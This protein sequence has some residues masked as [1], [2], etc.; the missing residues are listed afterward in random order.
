MN[1]ISIVLPVFN[2]L[3]Y[4]QNCIRTLDRLVLSST[5]YHV[6]FHII[7]VDDGSTDGTAD[8]L[9]EHYP[10]VHLLK[11]DGTLWWSGGVNMGA[12]YAIQDLDSDYILLWNNDIDPAE[13]YFTQLDSLISSTGRQMLLGSKIFYHG[14]N[15]KI[16]SYGGIFN[17]RSGNK[18][19]IGLDEPDSEKYNQV[20]SVDW[21]PGMGTLVPVGVIAQIGY[22]DQEIFPQYHGDS[23]FTYRAKIAGYELMVRPELRLWNDKTSSGLTHG[24]TLGGLIRVFSSVRS[25]L[26]IRKNIIFYRRY[27]TSW[28]AYLH[29]IGYYLRVIGGFFK[30]K[31]FSLFGKKRDEQAK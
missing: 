10:G 14:D 15:N 28:R 4:T 22:W 7:V 11:G 17:P 19:M 23:D 30:W 5:F 24:N 29:L 31:V 1:K 2:H 9:T 8:W 13:D 20:L 18:Y 12:R 27:A 26:N 21:L 25:N 6:K 3:E 16:W